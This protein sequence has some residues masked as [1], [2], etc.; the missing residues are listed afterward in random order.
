ML[1]CQVLLESRLVFAAL[2]AIG[3]PE[4]PI[5][6]FHTGF[7]VEA[8]QHCLAPVDLRDGFVQRNLGKVDVGIA[9]IA[10]DH[11]LAHGVDRFLPEALHILAHSE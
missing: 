7:P 4:R 8:L 9:V 6:P 10:H 2:V 5:C 1:R 3:K 11:P